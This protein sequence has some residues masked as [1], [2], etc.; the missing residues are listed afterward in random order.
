MAASRQWQGYGKKTLGIALIGSGVIGATHARAYRTI[1]YTYPDEV[2]PSLHV[3]VEATDELAQRAA[4]TWG[5]P[6]WTSNWESVMSDNDVEIVDICTPP[7]LHMSI[8]I[9]AAAAG[10]HVYCEKPLGRNSHETL[11]LWQAARDHGV[12]NFVGFNY[13]W[14]PA[15]QYARELITQGALGEPW[16]FHSTYNTWAGADPSSPWSWRY[17]RATAGHGAVSDVGSHVFDMARF[18]VGEITDLTGFTQCV[19]RERPVTDGRHGPKSRMLPVTN[20]DAWGAVFK[21]VNGATGVAEGSRVAAGSTVCFTIEVSGS[22]G[23]VR[24]DLTRMNELEV[25]RRQSESRLEG[26]TQILMGPSHPFQ[27]TFVPVAGLSIGYLELKVL[28]QRALLNAISQGVLVAP[29]FEDG[30][31]VARLLDRLAS[32]P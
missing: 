30:L 9:A 25:Y 3:V 20:D 18:L 8:G 2:Q 27:G 4:K 6:R 23:A 7:N 24:W 1:Q 5:V 13:R 12:S 32:S 19:V 16:H 26:F 10:K 22:E 14:S 31:I 21:F 28:E 29:T 11:S 17:D 15:I